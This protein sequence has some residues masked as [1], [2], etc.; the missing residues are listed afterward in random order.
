MFQLTADGGGCGVGGKGGASASD[1]KKV[2]SSLPFLFNEG[3][4][5]SHYQCVSRH[6]TVGRGGGRMEPV[7]ATTKKRSCSFSMRFHACINI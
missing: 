6:L 1:N 2:W 3:K 4:G 5:G 7:P